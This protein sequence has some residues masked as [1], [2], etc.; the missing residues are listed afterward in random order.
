MHE[1][2]KTKPCTRCGQML[3]LTEFSPCPHGR[4]GRYSRCKRCQALLTRIRR[5]Q[6]DGP[7]EAHR[8]WRKLHR[9]DASAAAQRWKRRHPERE[10]AHYAV[11]AALLGG[12]LRRPERCQG[13]GRVGR[14]VAHH[15]DYAR[16]LEVEWLCRRC[17]AR[18]HVDE[19]LQRGTR[20]A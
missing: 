15:A 3:P 19:R 20:A 4:Y 2:R 11:R 13:C 10:R 6:G 17:H 1:K 8:R 14:V 16:P 7:R 5:A 9:A 18:R 12:L